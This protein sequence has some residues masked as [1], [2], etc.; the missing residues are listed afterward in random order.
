V[1]YPHLHLMINHLPILG[2]VFAL[3]LVLWGTARGSRE[4]RRLALWVA[5]L[6]GLSVYPAHFTGDEAHEQVEEYPGFDHD[7]THEHEEAADWA[8]FVMLFTAGAAGATLFLGRGTRTEPGWARGA[9]LLGL[10]AS[11]ATVARAGWVGGEIRHEEIRG[12][13]TSAPT[14]PPGATPAEHTHGVQDGV[15]PAA[16]PVGGLDSA[17]TAAAAAATTAATDSAAP[18]K[19][20]HVHK[21]GKE[22]TH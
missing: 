19:K 9:V 8:L 11:V 16:V 21:D 18:K 5:L 12:P 17:A 14:I 3:L 20:V 2:S 10:V 1:N 7:A 15:A 22:H 6:A 4:V 13:L